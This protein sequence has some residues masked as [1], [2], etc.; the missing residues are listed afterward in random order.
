MEVI[1]LTFL[2]VPSRKHDLSIVTPYLSKR[3]SS[4]PKGTVPLV[5]LRRKSGFL[6]L[7]R[8]I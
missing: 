5:L 3:K 8:I 4:L 2:D 1:F 7:Y 6:F